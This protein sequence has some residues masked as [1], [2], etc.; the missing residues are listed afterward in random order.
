MRVCASILLLAFC[1]IAPSL[2][3]DEL[4]GKKMYDAK[5]AKCHGLK[6]E[7]VADVYDENLYGDRSFAELVKIINDTMPEDKPAEC[8]GEDALQVAEYMYESFY[9]AAARAKHRP[10]RIE[11]S[12]M[13]GP[14]YLN[15]VSDLASHF[16]GKRVPNEQ[17]GLEGTYYDSRSPHKDKERI[18][19]TDPVLKFDFKEGSPGE[20]IN[21]EEFSVIWTGGIIAD[22]T[23]DYQIGV[24]TENGFLLMLNESD[25]P[26][27]DGKVVSGEEVK[28]H[29]ATIRL[30][31]GR[32][33]PLRIDFYKS[34]RKGK[35]K[36]SASIELRWKPPHKEW[37]TIPE[38]HLAPG[39]FPNV[40]VPNT[41]FPADDSSLGYPR[42][43][44]ISRNWDTA[45]TYAALEFVDYVIGHVDRFTHH[46]KDKPLKEKCIAFCDEFSYMA[47]RRPLG[48]D[49]KKFYI[50]QRFEEQSDPTLALK[51]SL[52]LILKSPHF[53]YLNLDVGAPEAYVTASKLS[54]A[55]WDSIPDRALMDKASHNH[56][57][58]PQQVKGKVEQMLSDP[59][60]RLKL[61]GF[62]EHLLQLEEADDIDK[63][64]QEFPG[65]DEELLADLRTSLMLFVDNVVWSDTSDYRE[66]LLSNELYLNPRLAAFYDFP[67]ENH[68]GFEKV[69]FEKDQRAGVVT[70]P[71]LLSALAYHKSTS[72]IHRGVFVTRRILGRSLKPPPMAIE[73]MDNK[74]DP[75][76]TMREKVTELTKSKTCQTCHSVIN[77][78]GFSLEQFDAVGR[79][80]TKE[81]N[82]PVDPTGVYNSPEGKPI[83]LSGARDLAE[84][85]A[86]SH[87]AQQNFIEQLFH[88]LVKQP[89][90]AY[91]PE[92]LKQLRD[93]F[94]HNQYNIQKLIVDIAVTTATHNSA[95][96][97]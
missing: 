28:D 47:F 78:L 77:P 12:R 4:P 5:C 92:E 89:V 87:L 25:S 22:E 88:H 32:T 39:Y 3:D 68:R 60:V 26:L 65:F 29:Q 1:L 21:S 7:G 70:H 58:T 48:E 49:E 20:K 33:Y 38:R 30:L 16:I 84:Y 81:K 61:R 15:A 91:G 34:K 85:A 57:K 79:F 13:T 40:F 80:R 36:K 72:P 8:V 66:L 52:L 93:N 37:E 90:A 59:R 18:K 50:H 55:L 67:M 6:G 64:V 71:F 23:G 10:P 9:T 56:L 24:K 62:F 17:R 75:D 96:E 73:F 43:T 45:T 19:R 44:S 86:T 74:F 41:P 42:G 53:L 51:E 31:G 35:Q 76:L 94:E 95:Q 63:D 82:K 83:K 11:L 27:I 97:N 2:A 54:F 46:Y 14:Q 69:A